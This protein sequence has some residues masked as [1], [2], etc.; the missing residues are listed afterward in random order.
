MELEVGAEGGRRGCVWGLGC[1]GKGR[2]EGVLGIVVEWEGRRSVDYTITFQF[3]YSIHVNI[4][5]ANK[6]MLFEACKILFEESKCCYETLVCTKHVH[7]PVIGVFICVT[8]YQMC[9]EFVK[10]GS[11]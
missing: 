3:R 4:S 5:T 9:C 8:V 6:E 11:Q 10:V 7:M 1:S 2:R